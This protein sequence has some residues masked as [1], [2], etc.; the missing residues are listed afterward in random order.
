MSRTAIKLCNNHL[1]NSYHSSRTGLQQVGCVEHRGRG[2]FVGREYQW[3]G[4][5]VGGGGG[6][7][8]GGAAVAGKG[9]PEGKRGLLS[10]LCLWLYAGIEG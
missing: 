9:V 4:V 10:T 8:G 6:R 7:G 3:A 2:I 1:M 5:P